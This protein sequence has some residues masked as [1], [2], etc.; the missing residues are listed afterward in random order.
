MSSRTLPLVRRE[1]HRVPCGRP[2]TCVRAGDL[3]RSSSPVGWGLSIDLGAENLHSVSHHSRF[4]RSWSISAQINPPSAIVHLV[5]VAAAVGAT[6]CLIAPVSLHPILFRLHARRLL[7]G[8]G[9]RLVQ[10]GS[11]ATTGVVLLV[12][13]HRGRAR[14]AGHERCGDPAARPLAAPVASP[15]RAGR[16]PPGR[17]R[18][19]R[20]DHPGRA[21]GKRG[22]P[23]VARAPD[24]PCWLRPISRRIGVRS[25]R[26]GARGRGPCRGRCGATCAFRRRTAVCGWPHSGTGRRSGDPDRRSARRRP[27]AGPARGRAT[28]RPDTR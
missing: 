19:P 23:S 6:G 9:P 4:A 12:F 11:V 16:R 13:E 5:T 21:P 28:G 27:R 17:P 20:G 15:S 25:A 14:P 26:S 8:V 3:D 22:G 10:A 2:R 7:V 24:G 18:R 1:R